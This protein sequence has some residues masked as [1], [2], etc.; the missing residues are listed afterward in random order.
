MGWNGIERNRLDYILT[1][2]LPVEI[3]ELFSFSKFYEFLLQ[4]KQQE[5][6]KTI[7]QK[8]KKNKVENNEIMFQNGWS[9]KPLK[10]KILKGTNSMREMSVIQP[11]SALN[12]YLFVECYQGDILDF[13]EKHHDFSIRYHKKNTNLYYFSRSGK[14]T[15][16]FQKQFNRLGRG[17]IQQAGN[18]FK[19]APFE[20]INS[21]EDSRIWRMCNFKF[22]YFAKLDYKS[23]F[24]S[25]YTHAFTWIIERNV[26]DAKSANNSHLFLTIDRILQNIN[27]RSSNGIVVGPEFSRMMAE[28]LLQHIDREI[29]LSLTKENITN[30]V[31][32]VVYRYVDDIFVF[33]NQPYVID[34]VLEKYKIIGEKYF[35]RLNELKLA[36]DVTPYLRKEW[37]EKT[38]QLSDMIGGFFYKDSKL[39]FEKLPEDKR[40]LVRMEFIYID[41]LKDEVAFLVK[42]YPEDKRTIVSFVLST[43][44]N[45][46]SKKRNGYVLFGEKRLGKALLLIDLALYIYAFYSSFD[47][48]RKI[49]SI[50][51]YINN[52]FDF[53]N[54]NIARARLAETIKRYVFI[55]SSGNIFDLSD[56]FPFFSEYQIFLDART[57]KHLIEFLDDYHD[58]IMWA[59]ILLY[60]KYNKSFFGELVCKIEK[61]LVE[62]INRITYN[63]PM[64]QEEFWYILIFHNCPY[65][66]NDLKNEMSVLINRIKTHAAAQD[67]PS[68][69]TIEL[70]CEFLEQNFKNGGRKPKESFFN[71]NGIKNFA[72]QITYRTYQRTLFKRYRKNKYNLYVSL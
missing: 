10:Y 51:S 16:Y 49:I 60:S 17:A 65:I 28:I 4:K 69:N 52:E 59:N 26:V 45:N 36:R 8:I 3:S 42:K 46:I 54:N 72:D 33:A 11:L 58:P 19:I 25:I 14:I 40:Y 15:Q 66:S 43:L 13:F 30:D 2:L 32:Y 21:F 61:N 70:V 12:L 39:E 63:E 22:K 9:T 5:K 50:I 56:W 53:K 27:G 38:R 44:L 37:L 35:L 20:S 55:F 64:M 57:E 71:W 24:D 34:K 6:L 7:I 68:S 29:L 18:Y 31:D 41:R 62:H 47:Q 1:D 67:Y 23:C 48:T